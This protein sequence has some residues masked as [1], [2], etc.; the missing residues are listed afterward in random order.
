MSL[1]PLGESITL[2]QLRYFIA[3]ADAR[4]FSGAS[5]SLFVS[6]PTLTVAMQKLSHDLGV[7]LLTQ[8]EGGQELTEAGRILYD[9]GMRILDAVTELESTL[10]ASTRGEHSTLKVGFTHLFTMQFMP[11]ILQFIQTHPNTE[12][13]FVQGGSKN[14]QLRVANEQL[15]FALVSFPQF[16]ASLTLEELRTTVRDYDVCVVMRE[17]HPLAGRDDLTW[18]DLAGHELSSLNHDYVLFNVLH[19]EANRE[20]F[21]P[22]IVFTNDNESVLLTSVRQMNTLCVLPEAVFHHTPQPGL[23]CV[24]LAGRHSN[25]PIAVA[26]RRGSVMSSDM[27]DF[28]E[29]IHRN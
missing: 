11:Q 25:F 19:E 14:L 26:T 8:G 13:T 24:T 2:R 7:T 5:R 23:T 16:H 22:K 9:E 10:R 28:I 17:D 18:A 29:C 1:L 27:A 3:V 15:D 12:V 4:S 6:Q 20:G 21:T